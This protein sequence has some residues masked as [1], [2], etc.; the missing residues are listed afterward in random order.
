MKLDGGKT[1]LRDDDDDV[2]S[3]VFVR[4]HFQTFARIADCPQSV[5]TNKTHATGLS[6]SRIDYANYWDFIASI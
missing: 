2:S 6:S 1:R 5:D 3:S 4:L